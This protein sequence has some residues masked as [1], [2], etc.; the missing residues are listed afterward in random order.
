MGTDMRV[1][2]LILMSVM[3]SSCL[4][5][6]VKKTIQ[7]SATIAP[8]CVI[9]SSADSVKQ[10]CRGYENQNVVPVSIKTDGNTTTMYY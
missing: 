1:L 6:E 2:G 10:V 9:V 8:Y 7:V 3:F 4:A 5:G